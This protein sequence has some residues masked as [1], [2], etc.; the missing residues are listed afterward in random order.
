MMPHLS[1]ADYS[2][3]LERLGLEPTLR[4]VWSVVGNSSELQG[5]KLHLSS[6]PTEAI[7]L[8]SRVAPL[9]VERGVSL[10]VAKDES[11]LSLLNEGEL[12]ATQVG[13]FVTVYPH[14]DSQA[15]ELADELIKLTKGLHGPI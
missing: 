4:G 6:I 14:T 12:G 15:K 7:T 11:I 9:L 1:A 3:V 8:I 2:Q 10:K 5:W 13:K